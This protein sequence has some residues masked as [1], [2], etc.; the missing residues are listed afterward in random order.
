M[1]GFVSSAFVVDTTAKTMATACFTHF[2]VPNGLPRLVILDKDGANQ[3]ELQQMCQLMLI[4]HHLVSPKNHKAI[5]CERNHRYKNKVQK[6]H[7]TDCNTLDEWILGT[8][9]ADYAWNASPIDGTN[10][11]WSYAAKGREFP[12]PIDL[13]IEQQPQFHTTEGQAAIEHVETAFPLLLKQREVLRILNEERRLRHAEL[14]NEARNTKIFKPGDITIARKQV[15][16]RDGIPA[17]LT[18]RMK[19]PY[20]VLER[21][22]DEE[23]NDSSSYWIQRIPFLQ[24]LGRK[25]KRI[26]ESA[27]RMEKL[28]SELII[29][30]PIDGV[31]TRMATLESPFVPNPLEKY[32]RIH[33]FGKYKRT[34]DANFAYDR[35][36]DMWQEEIHDNNEDSD[37]DDD[38]GDDQDDDNTHEPN[39]DDQDNSNTQSSSQN[40]PFH[41]SI[42]ISRKRKSKRPTF[43]NIEHPHEVI[44]T[45]TALRRLRQRIKRSHHKLFL[46]HDPTDDEQKWKLI[47]VDM[48]ETDL[49][50]ANDWG[51]Y[52]VRF[53]HP[54]IR[55]S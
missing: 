45:A 22:K 43:R 39:D 13:S 1:T 37:D 18:F 53:Y 48:D 49:G 19:G 33:R 54:I 10:I 12:F 23:G 2:F 38:P 24:G 30:R 34:D 36:K 40:I 3:G 5:L 41:Q 21:I 35:V 44:S 8:N 20:R 31:D 52:F 14:K 28:P 51:Q 32:L 46:I 25:G 11:I 47:T 16:T 50:F 17:K 7:A 4:K 55:T 9:L 42:E 6:I 15:Q 27:A 26:K 29:Q